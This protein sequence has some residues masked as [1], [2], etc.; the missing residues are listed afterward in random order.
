MGDI[1][2]IQIPIRNIDNENN[3]EQTVNY[4]VAGSSYIKLPPFLI[5]KWE[6]INPQNNDNYCFKW[7]IL[8][9]HVTKLNKHRVKII[10]NTNKNIIFQG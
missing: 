1:P 2:N 8:E 4:T 9:K 6:T 5:N 7:S 3:N 10:I